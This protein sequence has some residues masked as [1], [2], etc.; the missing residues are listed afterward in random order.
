MGELAAIAVDPLIS[1]LERAN[2][3]SEFTVLRTSL[4]AA[5]GDVG[6]L[7]YRKT[8]SLVSQDN[9]LTTYINIGGGTITNTNIAQKY[10]VWEGLVDNLSLDTLANA[11]AAIQSLDT[12][13]QSFGRILANNSSNQSRW[14]RWIGWIEG[15]NSNLGGID[16]E[17]RSVDVAKTTAEY[18]SLQS[19]LQMGQYTASQMNTNPQNMLRFLNF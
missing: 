16:S 13:I 14:T 18:V 19:R 7:K 9:A 10:T 5:G 4:D 17:I 8:F 2:L 3:N 11:N 6:Y 12:R 15:F 1:S